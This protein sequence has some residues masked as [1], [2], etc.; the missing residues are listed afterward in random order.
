MKKHVLR[1]VCA[2]FLLF[3]TQTFAEGVS[4][5]IQDVK[6]QAGINYWYLHEPALPIVSVSMVFKN[7]GSLYDPEGKKG[8]A[9]LAASLVLRGTTKDGESISRK[10]KEKGVS[11]GVSVDEDNLYIH[12][13]TLAENLDF[14]LSMIGYSLVRAPI[15]DVSFLTEK[16]LQKASIKRDSGD[17]VALAKR[18]LYKMMFGDNPHAYR[19]SGTVETVDRITLEDIGNYRKDSFDLEQMILG[20]VGDVSAEDVSSMLDRYFSVVDRGHNTRIISAVEPSIGLRGYVRHEAPQSVIVFAAKGISQGDRDYRLA[21][22]LSDALGGI[23]LSSV[24]MQELREKRGIT[25]RVRSSMKHIRGVDLF[26]GVL[27]TDGATAEEGVE[28]LLET[29]EHIRVNGLDKRT[30]GISVASIISSFTFSFLDT[31]SASEMLTEM[32]LLGFDTDYVKEHDS[33]YR[34]ITLEDVNK[35]ARNFLRDFTIVEAGDAN[36]IGATVLS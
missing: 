16:E 35:F 23:G 22:V 18:M 8:L 5:D 33:I 15:D 32:Q 24:L 13:K 1:G 28:V 11:F 9:A 4:L 7:A 25:Y 6:T 26:T 3:C 31:A 19:V 12:L 20:I 17:P 21:Q 30:F 34:S 36:H 27:Y 14:A 10:L 29:I 2:I